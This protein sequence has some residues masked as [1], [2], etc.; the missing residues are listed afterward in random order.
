M[1]CVPL[2]PPP[3]VVDCD[4]LRESVVR[5]QADV[6]ARQQGIWDLEAH[7]RSRSPISACWSGSSKEKVGRFDT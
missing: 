6:D 3:P 7:G 1:A 4:K 5:A 2:V